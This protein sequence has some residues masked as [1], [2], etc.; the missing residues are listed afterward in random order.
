MADDW[1]GGIFYHLFF[2]FLLATLKA[3]V[4]ANLTHRYGIITRTEQKQ[5]HKNGCSYFEGRWVYDDSYPL[6]SSWNCPFLRGGF[7]CQRN[8][9]P[10]KKYLKYRWQPS[11]CNLPRWRKLFL[12]SVCLLVSFFSYGFNKKN[13]DI[14]LHFFKRSKRE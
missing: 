1:P 6:Y 8:G 2:V 11:A 4:H 10:D 9:R 14:R 12:L 13:T 7:D 3:K 5:R